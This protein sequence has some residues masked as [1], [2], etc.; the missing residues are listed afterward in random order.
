MR[1]TKTALPAQS[2][3]ND[4]PKTLFFGAIRK[5]PHWRLSKAPFETQGLKVLL[6]VFD[7]LVTADIR[8]VAASVKE[9]PFETFA[10]IYAEVSS[11]VFQKTGSVVDVKV[12]VI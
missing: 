9:G 6:Q 11:A 12:K 2:G 1:A 8:C 4:A 5:P 10:A 7:R 3:F